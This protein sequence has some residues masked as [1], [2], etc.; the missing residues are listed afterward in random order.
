MT[1]SIRILNLAI[2]LSG[3]ILCS[4]AIVL[5]FAGPKISRQV[6]RYLLWYYS[7]CSLLSAANMAGL[8]MRGLPGPGWRAALYVSNYTEFLLPN[9]LAYIITHYMLSI[10]DPEKKWK[11]LRRVNL[12][13]MLVHVV[14]LTISQFTGLFYIID[15]DNLY[16][17]QP[18]FPLA[19]LWTFIILLVAFTLLLRY[20]ARFTP[21]EFSVF[22][23]YFTV[24]FIALLLQAVQ[25]GI[26]FSVFST[27]IA[28]MAMYVFIVS[29]QTERYERERQEN[30]R[31]Q[32]SIKALQMRPHFI[33]NTMTSIYYLIVQDPKKAQ[34]VTLDFTNYL[35]NNF[36]ALAREGAIP[37][38]EELEHTRAYLAVEKV[39]YE[40][41]LFVRLDTPCTSFRL[42]PLTLQ[43]IVENAVIHG[44]S[45][46][47]EPLHLSVLTRA[48]ETGSEII[49]EDTGPGFLPSDD[50]APHIALA[51]IRD[52]LRTICGGTLEITEREHG[53]TRVRIFV[54]SSFL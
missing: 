53:G 26:N 17:R 15:P 22:I 16:R 29:D 32:A 23:I 34:Q 12:V 49:V 24:P 21:K 14:L 48:T 42:P 54:P 33:C 2:E 37:F 11:R 18:L 5:I 35:R 50:N 10:I 40:N 28:G 38:T 46:G 30:A 51:N 25:Y 36:T 3:V 52:R 6:R 13:L 44:V 1:E 43:P 27:I 8:V 31:R 39:R 7:C 45:P 47:L 9:V 41:K 19:L 20:R 4:M